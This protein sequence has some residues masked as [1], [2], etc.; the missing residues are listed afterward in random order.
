VDAL[1]LPYIWADLG[2]RFRMGSYFARADNAAE[3]INDH[4]LAAWSKRK[5]ME[6]GTNSLPASKVRLTKIWVRHRF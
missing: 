3:A 4:A 2:R 5:A 1:N 6:L